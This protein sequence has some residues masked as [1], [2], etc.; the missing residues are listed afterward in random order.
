MPPPVW[1]IR[2]FLAGPDAPAELVAAARAAIR[3]VSP[4]VLAHRVREV[5][6]SDVREDLRRVHVPTLALAGSQDRLVTSRAVDD[7]RVLGD[8][9]E[10]EILDGPHLILQRQPA[11]AAAAIRGFL[12]RR[13]EL[14]ARD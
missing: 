2:R 8:L 3:A 12:K 7:L 1:A 5:L 9:L 10:V 11:T 14:A 4:A 6:A 13:A